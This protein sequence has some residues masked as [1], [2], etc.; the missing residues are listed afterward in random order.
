MF[1]IVTG[2]NQFYFK[3]KKYLLVLLIAKN[4]VNGNVNRLWVRTLKLFN[5]LYSLAIIKQI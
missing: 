3:T 5:R 4:P 2:R 1:K